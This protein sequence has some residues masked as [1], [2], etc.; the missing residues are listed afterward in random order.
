MMKKYSIALFIIIPVLLLNGCTEQ[1][2]DKA[3]SLPIE[4]TF[5]KESRQWIDKKAEE[6]VEDFDSIPEA[7]AVR[8]K[9]DLLVAY[10]INHLSRFQLKEMDEK[11]KKKL[12]KDYKDLK[13]TVSHD[14]K[15]YLETEKL[16]EEIPH[17]KE[18]KIEK[19][20]KKIIDLSKEEA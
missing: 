8:T 6:A 2:D 20:V 1:K 11:I 3:H 9:D 13:I 10:K 15:I 12:K 19:K 18:K 14:I 4:K 5:N 7:I 17:L 16:K